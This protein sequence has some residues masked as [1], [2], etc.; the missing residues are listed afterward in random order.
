MDEKHGHGKLTDDNNLT[1][2]GKYSY[3]Y[4]GMFSEGKK[5]GQG[6]LQNRDGKTIYLGEWFNDFKHGQ[7]KEYYI[8]GSV[9]EGLYQ[10]GKKNGIGNITNTKTYT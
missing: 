5:C 3:Y 7:G 10:N 1:Y 2:I 9:Y 4:I 8:D 6:R